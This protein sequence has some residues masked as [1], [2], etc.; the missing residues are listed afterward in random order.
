LEPDSRLHRA[1][2]A[3]IRPAC[4]PACRMRSWCHPLCW[5]RSGPSPSLPSAPRV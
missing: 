5:L 3:K 4:H 2:S 1:L